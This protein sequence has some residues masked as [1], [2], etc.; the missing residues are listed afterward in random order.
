VRLPFAALAA[1]FLIAAAPAPTPPPSEARLGDDAYQVM[2]DHHE[3]IPNSP[4]AKWLAP[5]ASQL[6]RTADQMYG[7]PFQF[8]VHKSTE[9]NAYVIYG[10]RVYVNRGLIDLADNREEVAGV[11]CH[12]MSHAMHHDGVHDDKLQAQYDSRLAK[13]MNRVKGVWHGK[14]PRK[15]SGI[16]SFG[17]AL[18]W[19]HHSRVEETAADLSGSDLCARAGLNPWGLVWMFQKLAKLDEGGGPSW[20]SDHPDIKKR[21][22]DLKKHF[23]KFPAVFEIWSSDPSTGHLLKPSAK[24]KV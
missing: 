15:V 1:A 11:L 16:A 6:K 22:K 2:A 9:P 17:E 18:V 8:F 19:N 10:P 13:L 23:H 4:E 14:T 12:E 3:L 20:L 21:I 24:A 7:T 5:V